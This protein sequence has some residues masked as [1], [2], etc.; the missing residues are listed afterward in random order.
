MVRPRPLLERS[1]SLSLGST[2]E[3]VDSDTC[4]Q[5][6]MGRHLSRGENR[7]QWTLE[8]AEFH[9]NY[10]ELLAVFLAIQTFARP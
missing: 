5:D 3:F 4:F 6:G 8:E 1:L 7:G 9:I 10:L 2:A